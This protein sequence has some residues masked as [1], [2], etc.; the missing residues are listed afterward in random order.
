MTTQ[1]IEFVLSFFHI[2]GFV[3]WLGGGIFSVTAV[4][5]LLA[6]IRGE[7][8]SK[9]MAGFNI[10]V[11][12]IS[13]ISLALLVA[14]GLA[15]VWLVGAMNTDYLLSTLR[16]NTILVKMCLG[17]SI[18]TVGFIITF[19]ILPRLKAASLANAT[20]AD[21][22]PAGNLKIISLRKKLRILSMLNITTGIIAVFF[23][24]SLELL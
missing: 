7:E 16:G 5:P 14:S 19:Y 15:R 6:L 22:L 11:T 24:V 20:R 8:R 9:I 13:W 12:A 1:D 17:A 23:G 10:R 18:I 21:Q 2:M 3:I 4:T